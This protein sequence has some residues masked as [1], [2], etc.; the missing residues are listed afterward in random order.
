MATCQEPI[1]ENPP[2]VFRLLDVINRRTIE[3][4]ITKR[5]VDFV[6]AMQP[7]ASRPL[8]TGGSFFGRKFARPVRAYVLGKSTAHLHTLSAQGR[9]RFQRLVFPSLC[10]RSPISAVIRSKST[11]LTL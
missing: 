8:L 9:E 6:I 5:A 2:R 7:Q 4:E 10:C 3:A 1:Y 11:S